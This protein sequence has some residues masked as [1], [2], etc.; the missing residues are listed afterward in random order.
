[1]VGYRIVDAHYQ[2]AADKRAAVRDNLEMRDPK[3]FLARGGGRPGIE[4][5]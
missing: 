5:R 1:V 4:L 2:Q 3:V